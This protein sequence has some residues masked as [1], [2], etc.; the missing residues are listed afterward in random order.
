M[1]PM[2]WGMGGARGEVA[3][4]GCWVRRVNMIGFSRGGF[5]PAHKSH[6]SMEAGPKPASSRQRSFFFAIVYRLFASWP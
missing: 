6:Q 2:A 3:M 1:A 5:S 4:A